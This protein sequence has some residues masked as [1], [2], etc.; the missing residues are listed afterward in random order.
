MEDLGSTARRIDSRA[1]EIVR[2]FLKDQVVVTNLNFEVLLKVL[3]FYPFSDRTAT[4]LYFNSATTWS[5]LDLLVQFLLI[6]V[7]QSEAS[8]SVSL[9]AGA[10]MLYS[11]QALDTLFSQELGGKEWF[12]L[13]NNF[14]GGNVDVLNSL[15]LKFM[16]E[17]FILFSDKL[18]HKPSDFG[19][20]L[21]VAE[22]LIP[23]LSQVDSLDY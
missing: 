18:V 20:F 14:K 10:N 1:V 2:K 21:N 22:S 17:I 7:P 23:Y 5:D 16:G 8:K 13:K 12:D 4:I 19:D 3:E 15:V 9:L 6:K 11:M